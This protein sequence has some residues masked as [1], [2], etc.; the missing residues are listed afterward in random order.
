M[1][2]TDAKDPADVGTTMR[3]TAAARVEIAYARGRL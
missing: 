2:I 3:L 1:L